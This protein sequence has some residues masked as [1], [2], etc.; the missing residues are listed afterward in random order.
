MPHSS[1]S[2]SALSDGQRLFVADGGNDRVLIYNT[3]PTQSG[4]RADIILGQPDEFSDNTGDN[5]DGANAFQT[6]LALAWD[7][8]NL[9]VSDGYNRRIVVYSPAVGNVPLHGIR[10]A[11]SQEDSMPWAA[12]R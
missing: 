6:P 5:P 1:S 7:G 8:T 2:V 12:L 4:A 3:I 11:A 9:Y 10:N